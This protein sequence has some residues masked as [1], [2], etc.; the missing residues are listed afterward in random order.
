MIKI[1]VM[2]VLSKLDTGGLEN[3]V[4]NLC[5]NLDRARFEPMICCLNDIGPM[6]QRLK[7]DIRLFNLNLSDRRDLFYPLRLAAFFRKENPDIV[8]THGWG[9]W[10]L[11]AIIGARLGG[12]PVVIN[13]E[14]GS[15]FAKRHQIFLQRIIGLL[16]NIIL[17]VSDSLKN[18][19]TKRFAISKQRMKVIHNGVDTQIF[20]GNYDVFELK[21]ELLN[22]FNFYIDTNSLVI[23][24]VG[25]L[26]RQKNQTMLLQAIMALN[27]KRP[28]NNIK[29]IFVG[30]G[31]DRLMLEKYI[32]DNNMKKQVVFLGERNDI[33][34]LLSLFDVLVSTSLSEGLSNVILE[35][36]SSAVPVIAT[37]S[38]GTPELVYD[39]INGFIVY[40]PVD[41][42]GFAEKIKFL[43]DNPQ[44]LKTL[45]SNARKFIEENFSIKKMVS[46]YENIYLNSVNQGN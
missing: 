38:V 28:D 9:Q 21:E 14:H 36:M 41:A 16:S 46:S 17:S 29:V 10:S 11:Y 3:G 8:H 22:H 1:K 15:F 2:H 18:E 20:T 42:L 27:I 13:G 35:A 25:S 40:P 34:K 44:L 12:I 39:S 30:D 43:A 31:P 37:K 19:I 4:V 24:S 6:A 45:S 32:T 7:T 5:N 23:G 33:P 26:K